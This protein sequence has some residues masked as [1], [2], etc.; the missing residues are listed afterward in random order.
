MAA[1]QALSDVFFLAFIG[2]VAHFVTLEAEF[3]VTEERVVLA[4]AENARMLFSLV[5]TLHRLMTELLAPEALNCRV[6]INVIACSLCLKLVKHIIYFGV[7]R[8]F[9]LLL[10]RISFSIFAILFLL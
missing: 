6:R 3:G 5:G 8:L 7:F 1:T 9:A 2:L 4:T 10:T